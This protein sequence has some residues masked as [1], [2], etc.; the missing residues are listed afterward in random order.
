MNSIC[1]ATYNGE[2]YIYDQL[3]SILT[4]IDQNDEVIISDDGSIDR[5]LDII[6]NLNDP[7]III[8]NG[9][10]QNVIMN[11]ENALNY[12]KGE[13]IFLADQDD[14]WLPYK[15]SKCLTLLNVFDLVVSDAFVT[16][17][18]L[19]I[20]EQSFFK[21]YGSGKGI[22]KNIIRSTYFGSCMAFSKKIL[23]V[24]LP[25][26]DYNEIGH[27]LWI[28]LIAEM[29]G[30]VLFLNEP[31]ILYRRHADTFTNISTGLNRSQ[32]DL[33]RKIKGRIIMCKCLISFYFK[34]FQKSKLCK[35]D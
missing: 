18:K 17:D 6:R 21:H 33:S 12:A 5:T 22:I 7:R 9:N 4:Q 29:T 26:K 30:K 13:C 20:I 23:N 27:D 14:I 11:F 2:K 10:F 28:G 19:D 16:D 24:A 34:R 1:I 15:Y 3:V 25:F 8:L 32:R 31:L 35:K